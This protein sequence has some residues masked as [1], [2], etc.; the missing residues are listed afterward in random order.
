M[1]EILH[2]FTVS[3]VQNASLDATVKLDV[4]D[5]SIAIFEAVSEEMQ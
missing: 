5:A 3:N 2:G 1:S 4:A